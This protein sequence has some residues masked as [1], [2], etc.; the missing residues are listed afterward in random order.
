MA[1]KKERGYVALTG[2][3]TTVKAGT[4]AIGAAD[5]SVTFT[6]DI[7]DSTTTSVDYSIYSAFDNQLVDGPNTVAVIFGVPETVTTPN[8][9]TL[10]AG[11]Y[12]IVFTE[13]DLLWQI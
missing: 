4:T 8:P 1:G 3:G 5:G 12:Y 7:F 10:S 13:N 9:G 2:E 11:Q 6:I